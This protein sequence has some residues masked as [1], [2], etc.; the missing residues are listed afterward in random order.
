VGVVFIK[1]NNKKTQIPPVESLGID[2]QVDSLLP[3]QEYLLSPPG[4]KSRLPAILTNISTPKLIRK[5]P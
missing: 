5:K 1:D 4:K 3:R 2:L